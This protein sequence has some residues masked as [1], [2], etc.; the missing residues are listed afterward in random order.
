MTL[1]VFRNQGEGGLASAKVSRREQFSLGSL[2]DRSTLPDAAMNLRPAAQAGSRRETPATVL[3]SLTRRQKIWELG[4]SLHCSIIGT[5]LT[6]AE[7]RQALTKMNIAGIEAM[8]EHDLHKHGVTLAGYRDGTA[9]PLQKAL[10]RKHQRS[11]A[12][13]DLVTMEEELLHL[14]QDGVA[15]GDIPGAYWALLSHG[16]VTEKLTKRAFGEV[17]MLSHLMGAANRADIRRLSAME[18]E[19]EALKAKIERQQAQIHDIAVARDAKIRDLDRLLSQRLHSV[20]TVQEASAGGD[21]LL[22]VLERRLASEAGRR[23]SLEEKLAAADQRWK[24]AQD[25][26]ANASETIRRLE[27]ELALAESGL[28]LDGAVEE[29]VASHLAGRTLLYIGGMSGHVARLKSIAERFGAALLHHDG[30]LESQSTQ[31][32]ALVAQAS[33]VFFPVDC[34]SHDAMHQLKKACRQSAKPY[35]PL[36]SAGL[37]SFL[38]ALRSWQPQAAGAAF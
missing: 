29:P 27:Q 1:Q 10:D 23:Q 8:T 15:A 12:K 34:I 36:R 37:T 7:L 28:G 25:N 19:N 16:S 35:I 6:T 33:L 4:A 13:F 38:A 11:I 21:D 5:C 9:K 26:L 31:L 3:A 14:W 2:F 22:A 32:Q 17:H 18:T 20:G 30:G 24:V